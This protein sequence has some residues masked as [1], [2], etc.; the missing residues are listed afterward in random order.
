MES[1]RKLIIGG[2]ITGLALMG[3][4]L[5]MFYKRQLNL[6]MQYCYKIT[7]FTPIK[8]SKDMM[9]FELYMNI[10]NKSSFAMVLEG[11]AFDIYLNDKKVTHVVNK[12]NTP[13]K[14]N[15]V[16]SLHFTVNFD[17]K[18]FWDLTYILQLLSYFITDKSKIK[19]RIVGTMS[20]KADFIKV[21]AFPLD[22][23]MTVA[24]ILAPPDP[25]APK[26]VCNV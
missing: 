21:H 2:A 7:N 13:I 23:T 26:V 18:A 3:V 16:S 5:Y 15:G 20:A 25:N 4:G 24:D 8:V 22:I 6:A 19:I 14:N 9:S 10:E 17:P 1:N 11:Y 12:T